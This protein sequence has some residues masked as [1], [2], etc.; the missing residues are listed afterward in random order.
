LLNT[1]EADTSAAVVVDIQVVVSGMRAAA[2]ARPR[3][4]M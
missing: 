4:A 2:A 1:L 3:Q